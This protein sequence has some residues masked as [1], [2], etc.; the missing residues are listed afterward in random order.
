[1]RRSE[2]TK[3]VGIRT[4][5]F[6]FF[7]LFTIIAVAL[8]WLFQILLLPGFYTGIT[9]KAIANGAEQILSANNIDHMN[10]QAER[11]SLAHN[12]G[13]RVFVVEGTR[14][15]TVASVNDNFGSVIHIL[16]NKQLNELYD[17][18]E[19]DEDGAWVR[20]RLLDGDYRFA[21][22]ERGEG[23]RGDRVIDEREVYAL[24]DSAA[25][26]RTYFVLLDIPRQPIEGMVAVLGVQLIVLTVVLLFVSAVLAGLISK[27]ICT[28]I[29]CLN[30][31]ARDLPRGTYPQDYRVHA[32]REVAELSETLAEAAEEIGKTDALQKELIANVSH[33]L[34]TPLTMIIG[35]AEMMRDIEGE[36]TPENMQI[37]INE[38]KRLSDMVGDLVAIS[39]YQS[40]AETVETEEFSLSDEAAELLVEYRSLLEQDGFV[41]CDEIEEGI[42]VT[43]DRKRIVQVIR[44]LLDNAVNYGGDAKSVT[45][46]I[47]RIEGAVRVEVR[48]RGPGIPEDELKNIWQRYYRAKGNHPRSKSG[49]GLG[50]SIVRENLELHKARYGV[51]SV[52]G[53]EDGGE[54]G[55]AFW[56]E[57]PSQA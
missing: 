7:V 57:L 46:S 52:V 1:M 24:L 16:S 48:D 37:I 45:L 34:R 28:P 47:G 43:A 33:D 30:T 23:E 53:E 44:N 56:F 5:I 19:A 15:S 35:Y 54:S 50:L 11:V 8:L 29:A 32:Y 55:S 49:S 40:G 41:F 22:E 3:P 2:R 31:A 10:A 6:A 26:G 17:H 20:Y 39:R 25:D 12:A 38:A 51:E 9:R 27:R 13:V 36:S 21:W 18:A 4:K 42:L 14:V